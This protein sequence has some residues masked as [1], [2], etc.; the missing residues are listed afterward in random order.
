MSQT[1]TPLRSPA[2]PTRTG[3]CPRNTV[4][5]LQSERDNDNGHYSSP[6]EHLLPEDWSGGVLGRGPGPVLGLGRGAGSAPHL[7]HKHSKLLAAGEGNIIWS[8]IILIVRMMRRCGWGA[9]QST[10][11]GQSYPMMISI[12]RSEQIHTTIIYGSLFP[13]VGGDFHGLFLWPLAVHWPRGSLLWPGL[14]P[15]P[16]SGEKAGALCH[17]PKKVSWD[18]HKYKFGSVTISDVYTQL[19][20]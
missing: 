15:G 11:P 9:A 17:S 2:P 19:L 18:H 6:G 14:W 1:T 20:C 4:S 16:M 10:T 13:D 3:D 5:L 8:V 7:Q 12:S